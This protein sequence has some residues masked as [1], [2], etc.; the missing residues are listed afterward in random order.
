MIRFCKRLAGA[1]AYA[2]ATYKVL[3]VLIKL[4]RNQAEAK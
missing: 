4:L 2:M 3:S 1:A